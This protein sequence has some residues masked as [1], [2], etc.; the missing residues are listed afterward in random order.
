MNESKIAYLL[1]RV[2]NSKGRKLT[3]LNEY[4]YWSPFVAHHKPKLQINIHTGKWHCWVSETGG[5]SIFQLFKK[6][7]AQQKHFDELRELVD[8]DYWGAPRT[9]KTLKKSVL[10]PKEFKPLWNG[11]NSVI[12]THALSYLH[13]R[14]ISKEDIIKY[15]IGYCDVGLYTN[16]III[17]SYDSEG[18]LNFFVGRDFYKSKMKYR[19]SPT[20]K[21]VIGFELFVN[22]DEPI[23][24]VEG[25]LDAI[26]VKRNCIPLFGKTIMSS[27]YKQI[28]KNNVKTIY[29]CLDNDAM[30]DSLKMVENLL[31]EEIDIYLIRLDQ[32]DPNEVGFKNFI[33]SMDNT[34]KMSF[35]NLIR[36]KLNDKS[37]R[38]M[39]I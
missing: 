7:S 26:T 4:M 10:L 13:K 33:R 24:L 30:S 18:E 31:K 19:N 14:G 5:Y 38:Y 16:R 34:K 21:D 36:Y 6:I 29:I 17:P 39:E 8:D 37:K 22:W 27:L 28:M 9:Q 11:E 35:S 15:N 20:T 3:K 12:K 2:L 1:D 32:K 23:I 25:P